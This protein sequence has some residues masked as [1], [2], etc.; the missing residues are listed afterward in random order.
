VCVCVCARARVRERE[1][2]RERERDQTRGHMLPVLVFTVQSKCN[3][4][5]CTCD[6]FCLV[7]TKSGCLHLP[8]RGRVSAMTVNG[9]LKVTTML[10]WNVS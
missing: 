7:N 10:L 1:R 4:Y 2:E 3:L 9:I 8:Q 6:A 5:V